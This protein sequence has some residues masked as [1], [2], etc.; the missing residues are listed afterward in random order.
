MLPGP[1]Q[2]SPT[3]S[4]RIGACA[5]A[6][7]RA[8]PSGRS[9]ATIVGPAACAR[10]GTTSAAQRTARRLLMRDTRYTFDP[11]RP[12]PP[13]KNPYTL[14]VSFVRGVFLVLVLA[15]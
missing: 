15:G 7:V 4:K 10:A 9:R 5:A 6:G 8:L 11:F 12:R 2:C 3:R 1:C 13:A 14:K